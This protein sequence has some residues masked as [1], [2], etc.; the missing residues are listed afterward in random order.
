MFGAVVLN[1]RLLCGSRGRKIARSKSFTCQRIGMTRATIH[2][3]HTDIS[4]PPIAGVHFDNYFI[5]LPP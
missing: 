2:D 3:L 1:P 5:A 4:L